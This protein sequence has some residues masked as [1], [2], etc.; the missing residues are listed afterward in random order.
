[1]CRIYLLLI[2]CFCFFAACSSIPRLE[3]EGIVAYGFQNGDPMYDMISIKIEKVPGKI[4]PPFCVQ[5][6][7]SADLL[8]SDQLTELTVSK[9]LPEFEIPKYWP[10]TWKLKAL[11][12]H[13]FVGNGFFI[14]F[15]NGRLQFL[16]M[17][18]RQQDPDEPITKPVSPA[19]V[20][21]ADCHS[22]FTLP[23]TREQFVEIFGEPDREGSVSEVYY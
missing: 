23:L 14:S 16:G 12:N 11:E 3:K 8:R 10:Q 7:P 19:K 22:I 21:P 4:V 18:T 5:L 17:G 1:M 13:D 9:Y 2:T 15:K 20:G 6:S